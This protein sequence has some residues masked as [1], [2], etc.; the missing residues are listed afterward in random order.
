MPEPKPIESLSSIL[1]DP[2]LVIWGRSMADAKLLVEQ[3]KHLPLAEADYHGT[4]QVA[5]SAVKRLGVQLD[6]L[7]RIDFQHSDRLLEEAPDP[8]VPVTRRTVRV[9]PEVAKRVSVRE[10]IMNII[11]SS[12]SDILT[13]G[14]I[15]DQLRMV[16]VLAD[17]YSLA[18]TLEMMRK[19]GLL[20]LTSTGFWMVA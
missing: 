19:D 4:L 6:D 3:L 9:V 13:A 11:R 10:R 16:G 1:K 8:V 12:E 7:I 14:A 15:F 2:A 5:K 17:M 18:A 20:K